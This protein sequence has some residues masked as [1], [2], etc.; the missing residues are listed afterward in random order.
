MTRRPVVRGSTRRASP[1]RRRTARK[2]EYGAVF[3]SGEHI[4]GFPSAYE[5]A[6]LS[7]DGSTVAWM[8]Q[9]ISEQAPVMPGSD[10]ADE[11]KYTEPLWRRIGG[12][13][14]AS[15]RRVT[16]GSDPTSPQCEASGETQVPA[17]PSLSDPCQGPFDTR[18]SQRERKRGYGRTATLSRLPAAAERERHDRRVPRHRPRNRQ[19]RRTLGRRNPLTTCTSS[20]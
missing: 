2:A 3:P 16:G 18:P 9:Q 8:G 13:E 7:A 11:P 17:P 10:L 4:P 20:T 1:N 15:T 19:R 6:S 14:S 12:G 5:G